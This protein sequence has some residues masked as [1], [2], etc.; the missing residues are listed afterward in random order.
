MLAVGRDRLTPNGSAAEGWDPGGETI[1]RVFLYVCRC[2]SAGYS[3]IRHKMPTFASTV[4]RA[5]GRHRLLR[6]RRRP[7]PPPGDAAGRRHHPAAAAADRRNQGCRAVSASSRSVSLTSHRH[8]HQAARPSSPVA[9]AAAAF[10]LAAASTLSPAVVVTPAV[11]APLANRGGQLEE[12]GARD[13]GISVFITLTDRPRHRRFTLKLIT[14]FVAL[15][16]P[17][18]WA[19]FSLARSSLF[20]FTHLQFGS[21]LSLSLSHSVSQSVR[22]GGETVVGVLSAHNTESATAATAASPPSASTN[23]RSGRY[24]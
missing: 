8:R 4:M 10:H 11:T 17:F 18:P 21:S 7:S 23:E 13:E 15:C 1:W 19:P 24:R 20:F 5:F 9:P 12:G 16:L 3:V 6:Q 2:R 22:C 14:V